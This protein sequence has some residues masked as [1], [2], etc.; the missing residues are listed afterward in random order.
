MKKILLTGLIF[1]IIAGLVY[2]GPVVFSVE[3]RDLFLYVSGMS[4]AF[5]F[6]LLSLTMQVN[7]HGLVN[8]LYQT[9]SPMG[10]GFH[11]K[12][13]STEEDCDNDTGV[14]LTPSQLRRRRTFFKIVAVFF[15][16]ITIMWFVRFF[17]AFYEYIFD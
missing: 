1:I 11:K 16:L 6:A 2:A 14:I 12:Q 5:G 10:I 3:N 7:I 13:E 4:L 17:L 9:G 8:W 15:S